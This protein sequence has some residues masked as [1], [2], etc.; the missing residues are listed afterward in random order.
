MLNMDPSKKSYL[1]I[2]ALDLTE[3]TSLPL[4]PQLHY[5]FLTEHGI[6]DI[7]ACKAALSDPDT[8]TYDQ[9]F[10]D[11]A[12]K[13]GRKVPTRKSHN[14]KAK[15]HGLK[16]QPKKPLPRFFQAHGYLVTRELLQESSPSSRQDIVS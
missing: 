7:K 4:N 14:C 2:A 8:L 11:P 6:T 5:L 10:L 16:F 12:L 3:D 13:N 9:V 15:T 1:S